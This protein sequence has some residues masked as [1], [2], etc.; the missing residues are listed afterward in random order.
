MNLI[1]LKNVCK[2]Y[3]QGGI[4]KTGHLVQ[5]LKN[6]DLTVAPG[7]CMGLLGRSGSGKSTLGRL[8]LGLEKPDAGDVLF[9]GKSIRTMFSVEYREF[10]RNVQ[11]VFQNSL[12]SVNPRF[13]AAQI[14]AEPLMNFEAL[15]PR[16]LEMK[17]GEL[18]EQVGLPAADACKY[19]HQF[20]GGELQ[21]ICIARAVALAPQLIV[22]DEAVSSLDMLI[23]AKI[24]H[25]LKQLQDSLGVAY[26]FISHD[27]RVLVKMAHQMA[28]LSNGRIVE[29][30]A[31][32][33][34]TRHDSHPA[35]AALV[36]AVLPPSP[37][38]AA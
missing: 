20:S 28:V 38:A 9:N 24:I 31:P 34:T 10:R 19:P 32:D 6:I 15:T 5:V 16:A 1:E 11:V 26:L 18:L 4:F 36:N 13:T 7:T 35:F 21:R 25:L 17:I 3:R 22:L 37:D 14:I 12:G 30:I 2:S 29:H 27:I 23:Q 33:V 8:V